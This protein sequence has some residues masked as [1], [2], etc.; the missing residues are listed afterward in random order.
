MYIVRYADDFRI[1]CRDYDTANRT[2]IAVTNWLNE[3]L[4]LEVSEEKTKIVNAHKQYMEFLGF[5][6]RLHSKGTGYTVYSH[7]CDKAF[8]TVKK[9]LKQQA[10]NIANPRS[11]KTERTAI[12][13]ENA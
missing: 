1:F 6:I 4:K 7:M 10:K 13:T 5:K 9:D 2:K 11:P 8:E 12:T 3:R